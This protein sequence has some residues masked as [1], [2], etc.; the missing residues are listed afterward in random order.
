VNRY[1]IERFFA[2]FAGLRRDWAGSVW[3][4]HVFDFVEYFFDFKCLASGIFQPARS[5]TLL[6]KKSGSSR[7]LKYET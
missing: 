4:W 7:P 1:A 3:D 2:E 6:Q 5:A